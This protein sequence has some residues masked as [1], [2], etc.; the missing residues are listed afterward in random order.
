MNFSERLA[1]NLIRLREEAGLSSNE[2]AFRASLSQ[3]QVESFEAGDL[4]LRVEE[5]TKLAGALGVSVS[6]LTE[7]IAWRPDMGKAGEFEVSGE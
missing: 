7:G 3:A 5:M 2:L 4:L 1:A 6:A